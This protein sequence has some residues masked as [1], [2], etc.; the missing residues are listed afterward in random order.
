MGNK[1]SY[2]R[3][4]FTRNKGALVLGGLFSIVSAGTSIGIAFILQ[5]LFDVAVDGNLQDLLHVV[6]LTIG[7]LVITV[8]VELIYRTFV[9]RFYFRGLTNYKK[10]VFKQLL[11]KNINTFGEQ[12]TGR[13]LSGLSNDVNTIE[14]QYLENIFS[15]IK[16]IALFVGGLLSL[17]IIS[18]WI[19]LTVIGSAVLPLTVALVF[20]NRAQKKEKIV[21]EKNDRFISSL[22]DILGGFSVIKSFKAEAEIQT[23]FDDNNETLEWA[24]RNKRNTISNIDILSMV[25]GTLMLLIVIGVG[26]WLSIQGIVTAGSIVAC[27]QLMNY[28][29]GPV[30]VLPTAFSRRNAAIALIEK[31][32]TTLDQ[33]DNK[34]NL[35]AVS[36]LENG[37]RFDNVFFGY[38][39]DTMILNGVNCFLNKGNS[40][41]VVG[42]SGSGKT[43]MLNLLMGLYTNYSGSV[44]FDT[45]QIRDIATESLYSLVSVVQQNVFIFDDDII[46]NITMYKPFPQEEINRAIDYSGLREL[47]E[48][49]GFDYKCGEGGSRLS[50][51]ERQ[52]ISIA[53]AIL[54]KMEILLMDEATSALDNQT[55]R[56]VEEAILSLSGI[57]R[58]VVTHKYNG[59][60]LKKYDEII[61]L[62]DGIIEEMGPFEK[63]LNANGYFSSLYRVSATTIE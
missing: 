25:A 16:S 3:S 20:G 55:A 18:P 41:A 63:L 5:Y 50:G 13:Y 62:K 59:E 10:F 2:A 11:T 52:R 17:F 21:S 42:V 57:T 35:V 58:I 23:I 30:Q 12:Q 31:M 39:D 7:L 61:V 26:V 33:P 43:T 14:V 40:Y 22:R 8:I 15:I 53:R 60:I 36:K 49:K 34:G 29:T 19:G 56:E 28:I 46:S 51:G 54:K 47:I 24:K 4:I 27:I 38:E 44:L 9:H 45:F 32:K 1:N 6:F 48:K 37:I